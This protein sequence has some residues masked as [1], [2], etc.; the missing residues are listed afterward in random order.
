MARLW[1]NGSAPSPGRTARSAWRRLDVGITQY[2]VAEQ[3]PRPGGYCAGRG[4]Q[5]RLRGRVHA[6]R[7]SGLL[8]RRRVHRRAGRARAADAQQGPQRRSA[9]PS[10]RRL[11]QATG[12]PI[13]LDYVARPNDWPFDHDRSPW[14]HV[15]RIKVPVL[16]IDGGATASSAAIS[17][18]TRRSPSARVSRPGSH[19]GPVHDKGCGAPFAPFT[20][21]PGLDDLTAMQV[22]FFRPPPRRRRHRAPRERRATT[23]KARTPTARRPVA[24]AG[25]EVR[26][27]L[28]RPGRDHS[29]EAEGPRCVGVLHQSG[30]RLRMRSTST[31]RSRSRRT[32]RPTSALDTGQGITRR[33]APLDAPLM[34]AGPTRLRLYASST[35]TDTDWHREA[36]R[37]RA[38]RHGVD[39]HRG[40]P[41]APRTARST[42]PAAR[43]P[44]RTTTNEHPKPLEPGAV[45]RFDIA[46][47]PTAYRLE[48]GHRLQLRFTTY[49]MPM[50]L[51][52]RY[53]VDRK[54]RVLG[55]HRTVAAGDEHGPGGRQARVFAAATGPGLRRQ[56][57]GLAAGDHQVVGSRPAPGSGAPAG[58]C[59][60][61]GGAGSRGTRTGAIAMGCPRRLRWP[62]GCGS[63]SRVSW[64]AAPRRRRALRRASGALGV[65]GELVGREGVDVDVGLQRV[66]VE[67]AARGAVRRALCSAGRARTSARHPGET[68]AG[69]SGV[70]G[71]PV[72]HPGRLAREE[73]H[74]ARAQDPAELP[75]RG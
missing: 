5:R 67:A 1:S 25:D 3:Q 63:P 46:V 27:L 73:E 71:D 69:R 35:A 48:P 75:K 4:A 31:E 55:Q 44:T 2:L 12:T 17:R 30:R 21:P 28:P 6:Q 57:A 59:R 32:C 22:E 24:A 13:A 20:N 66:I 70:G 36:R 39:H 47:Y 33:T 15:D 11:P 45:Y 34:L 42:R 14:Y 72:A 49:D 16:A 62:P 68:A 64:R 7:H 60:A 56:S 29:Q 50:H 38:G 53:K 41:S 8:L 74:P 43:P 40:L 52:G 61:A 23:S 18:C 58:G 65:R 9:D 26:A 37:R 10:T 51:P 54:D 19:L